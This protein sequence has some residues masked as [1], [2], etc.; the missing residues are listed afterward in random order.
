MFVL[1]LQLVSDF[2]MTIDHNVLDR[3][4]ERI[5]R[6]ELTTST[7]AKSRSNQAELYPQKFSNLAP[8]TEAPQVGFEPTTVSLGN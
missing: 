8:F 5:M 2:D 3:V 4:S 7:L 1:F 6:F